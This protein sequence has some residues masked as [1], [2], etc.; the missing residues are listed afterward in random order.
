[1]YTMILLLTKSTYET[2]TEEVIDWLIALGQKYQRVNG[3]D[4]LDI[5]Y[6]TDTIKSIWYWKWGFEHTA[7]ISMDSDQNAQK[8]YN[9]LV[10]EYK[11]QSNFLKYKLRNSYW[12]SH[13]ET[14]FVNK[15]I[16]LDKAKILGF[17]IADFSII[18]TK[19]E[20]VTFK[21]KYTRV[22]TKSMDNGT[23]LISKGYSVLFYTQEITNDHIL[24]LPD[25]FPN[26][27][28]Q[29]FIDKKYEIRVF[30]LTGKIY[31]MAIM[32]PDNDVDYRKHPE[33]L[34][35]IPYQLPQGTEDKI[36][37]LMKEMRLNTAS[38]D[39]ICGKDDVLY[40]L[41]VNPI[42]QLGMVSHPCNY[43]LEKEIATNLACL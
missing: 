24:Q 36:L 41:E 23:P 7:Q 1:M 3:N 6:D 11:A 8:L 40:F 17:S 30:F 22:I 29:R 20:L 35:K 43:Y 16:V 21:E 2:T 39:F 32:T 33:K 31:A 15:L 38:I 42:G 25:H 13:P 34:R 18:N 9:N 27:F 26:S 4:F 14:A 5:D 10:H 28:C 37:L 19:K 12:L